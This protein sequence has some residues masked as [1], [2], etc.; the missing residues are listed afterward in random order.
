M[1]VKDVHLVVLL[2]M[3]S[4]LLLYAYNA[5]GRPTLCTACS[6]KKETAGSYGLCF[7]TT[8][9]VLTEAR[10]ILDFMR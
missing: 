8:C 7:P 6:L 1:F 4:F 5:F 10:E 2:V 3:I 9:L